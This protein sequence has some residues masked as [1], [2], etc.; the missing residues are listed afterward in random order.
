MASL[1]PRLK[2]RAGVAHVPQ[3]VSTVAFVEQRRGTAHSRGYTGQW[4]KARLGYLAKHPLCCCHLAN[5]KTVAASVVDH[6]VP[7]SGDMVLFWDSSNWQPLCKWCHDTIKKSIEYL[8]QMGR[9]D[10]QL[11]SLSR[12]L[13]TYFGHP[14]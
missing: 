7:H 10:K 3:A 4:A 9:L 6:I 12:P 1:P 5:G 2:A 11:L 13:P 14:T 8:W